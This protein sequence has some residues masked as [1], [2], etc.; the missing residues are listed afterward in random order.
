[1]SL[2]EVRK[3]IQL[4]RQNPGKEAKDQI[5]IIAA[6]LTSEKYGVPNLDVNWREEKVIS[7]MKIR[8][9]SGQ[10][11]ILTVPQKKT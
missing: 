5:K 1:M 8:L 3:T 2:N 10:D 4:L 7:E 9:L 6:S 11:N